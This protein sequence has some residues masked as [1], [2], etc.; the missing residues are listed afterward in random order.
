MLFQTTSSK[1]VNPASNN[2]I[3][4][5]YLNPFMQDSQNDD[6]NELFGS[7]Q[8]SIQSMNKLSNKN[9]DTNHSNYQNKNIFI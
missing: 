9:A 3:S 6:C 4:S 2:T 7:I 8:N 1:Y 5:M